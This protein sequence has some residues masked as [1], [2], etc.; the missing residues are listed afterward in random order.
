VTPPADHGPH[1][2]LLE[3]I[4]LQRVGCEL[5]GSALYARVLAAVAADVR[6]GGPSRG[7]LAPHAEAPVGDAV[8]LRLLAGVH[9]LVL[10]GEAPYLA[11]HYPSVGGRAGRRL[12]V[13]FL[14]VVAAHADVLGRDLTA[15]VQTNEPGRSAALLPG[16][17]ELGRL[18]LPLQVLEVGAS[19]G[20]NLLFDRYHYRQGH[21]SWGPAASPLAVEA[22][23]VGPPPTDAPPIRVVGRRGCDLDPIDPTTAAGGTRLRSFVWPD[24]PDRRARLEAA[25]AVAAEYPVTVDR[26]DAVSWLAHRLTQRPPGTVTVVSHSIVFQYLTAADQRR[27]LTTLETVGAGADATAPLA[28]LRMEPAGDRADVRLTCWPDG[29]TRRVARSAYHG[30]PVVLDGAPA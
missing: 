13:D 9:R 16:Y 27:F 17:L 29:R 4:E 30:P 18:G 25:L 19:A 10:T 21:W 14:A 11:A 28:W 24:Q 12:E 2:R 1:R 6:A 23:F 26:A 22:P 3:T 15:G 5:A 7:L 8:L 20:L